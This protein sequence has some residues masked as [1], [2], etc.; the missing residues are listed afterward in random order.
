MDRFWELVNRFKDR[1]KYGDEYRVPYRLVQETVPHFWREESETIDDWI[2]R[3]FR[4]AG[5]VARISNV[6]GPGGESGTR[7]VALSHEDLGRGRRLAP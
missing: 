4:G 1:T 2:V 3:A 5:V 6:G 7:V